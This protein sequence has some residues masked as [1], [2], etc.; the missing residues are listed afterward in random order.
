[1]MEQNWTVEHKIPEE[2]EKL[3][4]DMLKDST[5]GVGWF[6]LM[7]LGGISMLFGPSWLATAGGVAMFISIIPAAYGKSKAENSE[8]AYKK[9]FKQWEATRGY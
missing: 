1:M 9:A 5:K 2:L 4:E 8:M 6:W 3:R 7:I